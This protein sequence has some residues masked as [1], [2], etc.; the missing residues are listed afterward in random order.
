MYQL[1][2]GHDLYPDEVYDVTTLCDPRF[3]RQAAAHGT[4]RTCTQRYMCLQTC[5]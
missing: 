5:K 3:D 1:H 4:I 2:A